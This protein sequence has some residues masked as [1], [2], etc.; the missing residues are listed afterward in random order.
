MKFNST[1]YEHAQALADYERAVAVAPG[2]VASR[3][4]QARMLLALGRKADAREI[5]EVLLRLQPE[6]VEAR[7]LLLRSLDE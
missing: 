3:V 4:G 1:T 6:H 2:H 7:R 5:V